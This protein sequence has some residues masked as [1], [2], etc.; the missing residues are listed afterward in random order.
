[1]DRFQ[2]FFFK[3]YGE[4]Y[5]I[6]PGASYTRPADKRPI[7]GIAWSGEG[8]INGNRLGAGEAFENAKE[9]L[10]IAGQPFTLTNTQQSGAL[11]VYTVFPYDESIED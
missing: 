9:F 7:A 3:F 10:V 4:G 2:I 6:Q 11:I 8:T 1:L 5:E